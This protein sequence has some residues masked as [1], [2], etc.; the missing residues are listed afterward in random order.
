MDTIVE[1]SSQIHMVVILPQAVNDRI[2]QRTSHQTYLMTILKKRKCKGGSH[3]SGPD[4]SNNTH[5]KYLLLCCDYMFTAESHQLLYAKA[6]LSRRFRHLIYLRIISNIMRN[7]SY[8]EYKLCCEKS[9]LTN[10]TNFTPEL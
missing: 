5:Y 7:I 2:V 6:T 9:Q 8:H 10:E 3:L 4:Q 1:R